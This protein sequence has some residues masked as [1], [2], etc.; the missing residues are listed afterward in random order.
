M[1]TYL[2]SLEDL[3]DAFLEE[4]RV[5]WRLYS[6]TGYNGA[7]RGDND[8]DPRKEDHGAITDL[9]ASW[10]KLVRVLHR[11]GQGTFTVVL[12]DK[13]GTINK[14][15]IQHTIKLGSDIASPNMGMPTGSFMNFQNFM[16]FY[17]LINNQGTENVGGIVESAVLEVKKDLEIEKLKDR[18]K[19]LEE[20]GPREKII[21]EGIKR[22]PDILDRF[23]PGETKAV[24]Q[25]GILGTAGIPQDVDAPVESGQDQAVD[26]NFSI[27]QAVTACLKIQE[28]L[29]DHHVNNLLW[30]LAN[31]IEDKPEQAQ[32]L[33]GML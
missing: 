2:N 26:G 16:E 17:N 3:Q 8:Y 18:V 22:L 23:F 25:A 10:D 11:Y 9:E 7:K 32:T 29:P 31:F 5:Y 6:G 4:G 21:E 14:R 27:D 1:T 30:K 13:P 19:E 12:F 24:A 15:G 33:I 28:L 20:G